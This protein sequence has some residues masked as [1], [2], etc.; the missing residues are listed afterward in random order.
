MN[1]LMQGS[2]SVKWEY[3]VIK[4]YHSQREIEG[5][6]MARGVMQITARHKTLGS[7]MK[8]EIERCRG[9]RGLRKLLMEK[10]DWNGRIKKSLI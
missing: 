3:W 8:H 4:P 10:L 2:V 6:P 5:G 7:F 1:G 9:L